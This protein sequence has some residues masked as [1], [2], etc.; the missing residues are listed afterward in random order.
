MKRLSFFLLFSFLLF[1]CNEKINSADQE[2]KT[3][4]EQDSIDQQNSIHKKDSVSPIPEP[5][6]QA[7]S[8]DPYECRGEVEG[9]IA[10]QNGAT[11]FRDIPGGKIIRQADFSDGEH[12]NVHVIADSSFGGWLHIKKLYDRDRDSV[13]KGFEGLWIYGGLVWCG[14]PDN[15]LRK[16]LREQP[17][18]NS[19]RVDAIY[20]GASIPVMGCCGKWVFTDYTDSDGK[21]HTGWVRPEFL[22]ANPYTNCC[23]DVN[24]D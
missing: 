21:H 9:Y 7:A 18:L 23:G 19:K 15:T 20:T 24:Q 17:D 10:D 2:T 16:S 3:K 22:C 5:Q 8:I 11:N 14:L 12:E 1:S 13:Y 4:T 6:Q